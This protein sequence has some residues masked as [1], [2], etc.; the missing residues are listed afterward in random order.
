MDIIAIREQLSNDF[1]K[2]DLTDEPLTT[3][4]RIF[5]TEP[6]IP[7]D[8]YVETAS[9]LDGWHHYVGLTLNGQRLGAAVASDDEVYLEEQPGSPRAYTCLRDVLLAFLPEKTV[10]NV[11]PPLWEPVSI[12]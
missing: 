11:M 3:T 6:N 1:D 4:T 7:Y 8:C 2:H 5:F 12:I 10:N 9:D